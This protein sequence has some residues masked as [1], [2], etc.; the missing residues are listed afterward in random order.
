MLARPLLC[1]LSMKTIA[2]LISQKKYVRNSLITLY[3]LLVL[4]ISATARAQNTVMPIFNGDE[5]V[6]TEVYQ[7]QVVL[8]MN[9]QVFLVVSNKEFYELQSNVDLSEYNG[10]QVVVEAYE[11]KHKVGPVF[12]TASLDPLQGDE[13]E[14][15]AAPVLI[16]FGISEAAN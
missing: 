16:V 15:V 10:E 2:T 13:I 14:P 8:A 12:E 6:Q 3:V 11:V 1:P 9:G 5:Q 4:G 7:G